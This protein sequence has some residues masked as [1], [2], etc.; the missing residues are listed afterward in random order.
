MGSREPSNSVTGRPALSERSPRN[1]WIPLMSTLVLFG[2]SNLYFFFLPHDQD[3]R[4]SFEQSLPLRGVVPGA[5]HPINAGHFASFGLTKGDLVDARCDRLPF[6][7]HGLTGVVPLSWRSRR[8][9]GDAT[10]HSRHHLRLRN[11]RFT[12]LAA[13]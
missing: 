8:A 9:A 5:P 12:H 2:A 11:V 10:P 3:R 13:R 6:L 1:V 7:W 4:R